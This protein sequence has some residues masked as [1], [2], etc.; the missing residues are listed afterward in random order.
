[1]KRLNLNLLSVLRGAVSIMGVLIDFLMGETFKDLG[2]FLMILGHFL[3][4]N[5]TIFFKD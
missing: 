1:M 3:I 5:F 4:L 2:N